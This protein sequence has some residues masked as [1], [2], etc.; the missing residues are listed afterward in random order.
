MDWTGLKLLL[1][2]IEPRRQNKRYRL[3]RNEA[4][5]MGA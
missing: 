4:Q 3:L 5:E 2:G 1:E